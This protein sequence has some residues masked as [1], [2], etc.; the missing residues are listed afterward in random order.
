LQGNSEIRTRCRLQP[1]PK[2]VVSRTLTNADWAGTTIISGDVAAQVARLKQEES[3]EVQVSGSRE[4]VQ[5]LLQHDLI[6]E[7]RLM[8]FPVLAGSGKRLS[9]EGTIPRGPR[10]IEHRALSSGVTIGIYERAETLEVGA[11]EPELQSE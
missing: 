8:T 3:G 4:L 11:Y 6:D 5:A 7:Y 10:L 1:D 9:A 2:Y